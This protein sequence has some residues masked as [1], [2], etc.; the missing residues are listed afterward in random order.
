MAQKDRISV[1]VSDM[2]EQIDCRTDVAWQELSLAGKI[3]TLLRE[4]LDQMK[5]GDKQT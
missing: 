3:R 1:D 5:S 2:R 4:R